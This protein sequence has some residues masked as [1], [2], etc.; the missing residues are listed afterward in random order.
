MDKFP[1]DAPKRRV[2]RAFEILGFNIV[3]EREHIFYAQK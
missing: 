3:K 2:I 1:K